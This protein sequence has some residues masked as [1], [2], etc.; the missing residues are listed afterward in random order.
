MLRLAL[1][2]ARAFVFEAV[3]V[4]VFYL[5]PALFL[6]GSVSCIAF[7]PT[8]HPQSPYFALEFLSSCAY[9]LADIVLVGL[10]IAAIDHFV[11]DHDADDVAVA[12]RELDR[13]VDLALVAIGALVDPRADHDL[14]AEFGGDGRHELVAFRRRVQSDRACQRRELLHVGA[15]LV[16]VAVDDGMSGFEGG[17]GQA[18]QHAVEIGRRLLVLQQGPKSGM[19]GGDKDKNSDDG[20]HRNQTMRG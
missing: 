3:D 17:V 11:A 7:P 12:A 14:E 19:N 5:S 20:A 6:V 2:S 8:F 4:Y 18:W 15:N 9:F 16:G 10:L 13:G 1:R